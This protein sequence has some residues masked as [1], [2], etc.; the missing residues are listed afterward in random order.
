MPD[1]F[2]TSER[3]RECALVLDGLVAAIRATSADDLAYTIEEVG[4][5]V[6][7]LERDGLACHP[8]TW[9]MRTFGVLLVAE[10]DRHDA[11]LE[12]GLRRILDGAAD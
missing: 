1:D 6:A 8:T 11:E 7:S 2:A 5:L 12:F 4:D 9:L 10:A 3:T